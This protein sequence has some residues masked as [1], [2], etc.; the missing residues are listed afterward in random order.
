[1]S[2]VTPQTYTGLL[3]VLPNPNSGEQSVAIADMVTIL[4]LYNESIYTAQQC[5][6]AVVARLGR[7]LTS[8]EATDLVAFQQYVQSGGSDSIT[9]LERCRIG[10][11][12]PERDFGLTDTEIRQVIGI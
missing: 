5:E 6:D 10:F 11:E 12:A 7:T 4:A 3:N 2:G 8:D 9:R 1:M